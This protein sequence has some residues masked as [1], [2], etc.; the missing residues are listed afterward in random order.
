MV[1]NH[2]PH[3]LAIPFPSEGHINPLLNF[4][5]R[6][7]SKGIRVTIIIATSSRKSAETQD[8]DLF[9]IE[10]IS[11]GSNERVEPE[12][13]EAYM[14]RLY[15]AMSKG[16][17]RL[18]ESLQSSIHP[19]KVVVYDSTLTWALD[20]AHQFGLLGASFFTQSCA[21][22]TLYYHM[23]QGT[24][25]I[26]HEQSSVSIPGLQ[27]LEINDF[28]SFSFFMDAN[29]TIPKLIAGQFANLHKA[30]WIFFNTFEKLQDEVHGNFN[31]IRHFI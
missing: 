22:C 28:P 18:I 4:S 23:Y 24:L 1:E 19:A 15:A 10:Y 7:A 30:N 21:V 31:Y 2:H 13:L 27:S 14:K 20:I 8:S 6:L 17:M 26:P 16:L 12:S 9:N 29:Q 25:K 5:K 3:V 11:D